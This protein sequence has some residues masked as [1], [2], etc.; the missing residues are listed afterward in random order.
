MINTKDI[1]DKFDPPLQ[2]FSS[3]RV[4]SVKIQKAQIS[5]N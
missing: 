4:D 1:I 3:K 2:M 5:A